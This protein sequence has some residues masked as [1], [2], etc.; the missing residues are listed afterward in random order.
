[1]EHFPIEITLLPNL[2]EFHF[3]QLNGRKIDELPDEIGTSLIFHLFVDNN[4]LTEIP[5]ATVKVHDV[6]IYW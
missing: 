3:D 4:A 5:S 1:M 6:Q 2:V